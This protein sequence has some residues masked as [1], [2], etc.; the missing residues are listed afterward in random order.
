MPRMFEAPRLGARA[1]LAERPVRPHQA[2]RA[3]LRL[4]ALNSPSFVLNLFDNA[5]RVATRTKVEQPAVNQVHLARQDRRRRDR[6]LRGG[7][8]RRHRNGL[9]GRPV[10]RG[11]AGPRRRLHDCRTQRRGISD[12]VEP[13]DAPMWPSDTTWRTQQ[14]DRGH[15]AADG[16]TEIDVLVVWTPA[17]RSGAGGTS[18]IQS[19]VLSAVANA[20]LAYSEQPGERPPAA[21]PQHRDRFH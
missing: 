16:A 4:E 20:N 9:S 14:H 21:G 18:A 10:V 6:D 1:R 12:D 13:L 2:R 19:L 11:H 7:R 3:R 15:A 17:A 8:W 5:E